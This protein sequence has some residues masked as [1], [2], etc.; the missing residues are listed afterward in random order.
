MDEEKRKS[1]ISEGFFSLG[2]SYYVVA[3][4]A[5][6]GFLMPITG[7]L[8]HH[9]IE[10][11][12]KGRLAKEMSSPD[13]KA[14]GHD[15]AQLWEHFKVLA[16]L[17]SLGTFDPLI[18]ELQQHER[19]RYPERIVDEGMQASVS[20]GGA[21]APRSLTPGDQPPS[22]HID[23]DRLDQLVA[24]IFRA[25]SVNPAFFFGALHPSLQEH[26]PRTLMDQ[27]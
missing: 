13:L 6:Q 14:L 21:P 12:L 25:S 11:L 18:L 10:M 15:L 2:S 3:R 16:G 24:S 9:A 4:I 20:L 26:I 22:Y 27:S 5:A 19:I 17:S 7:N 1:R 8:Y 23:V